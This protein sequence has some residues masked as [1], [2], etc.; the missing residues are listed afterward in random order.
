L[1]CKKYKVNLILLAQNELGNHE[2][3]F[4]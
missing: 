2:S 1:I 3:D 4:T